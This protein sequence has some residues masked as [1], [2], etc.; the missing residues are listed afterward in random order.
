MTTSFIQFQWPL[1][2]WNNW[3]YVLM[4][5]GKAA[6]VC[7]LLISL[8]QSSPLSHYQS[9]YTDN[10]FA[11]VYFM[12][13][14]TNLESVFDIRQGAFSSVKY[15]SLIG[16]LSSNNWERE[17]FTLEFI[18]GAVARYITIVNKRIWRNLPKYEE[19][20]LT[21]AISF[22]DD[23][24]ACVSL[25]ESVYLRFHKTQS[26]LILLWCLI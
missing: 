7:I 3:K 18:R 13:A 24:F 15:K 21:K 6:A 26:M 20:K 12:A 14:P 1:Q 16:D 10:R 19:I 17:M 25:H 9:H 22:W 23:G 5:K 8:T 11:H 2:A 4:P